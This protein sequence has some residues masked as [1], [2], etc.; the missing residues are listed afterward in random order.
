MGLPWTAYMVGILWQSHGV[1]TIW[2]VWQLGVVNVGHIRLHHEGFGAL[3]I[4]RKAPAVTYRGRLLV[5]S[6]EWM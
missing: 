1:S 3:M 6:S 4:E 2:V 5:P